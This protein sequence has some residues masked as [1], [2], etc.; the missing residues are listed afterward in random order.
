MCEYSHAMGNSN[1]SLADYWAAIEATP[2]LQGGFVWEW[3][4]HGLRQQLPDG[5]TRLAYGGQFG[6]RRHDGNFVADGLMSA[7]LEPHPA[8]TEVAWVHRPI[9]VAAGD[10]GG[11]VV[12]N[13]QSFTDASVLDA[14]WELLLD[15][16]A[17][18]GGT[19]SLPSVPP[20]ARV[21][22][23]IPC[24]VPA[25]AGEAHLALRFAHRDAT[26]FAPAGHV[27]AWDQ[28][29][30]R[31]ATS[32]RRS[33]G[34]VAAAVGVPELQLWRAPIDND[35]FKLM[36]WMA[37][38]GVGGAAMAGWQHAGLDGTPADEL[39]DHRV[40]RHADGRFEHQV[41]L[42]D[43]FPDPARVGVQFML[44]ARFTRV[45]WFG[46][47]PGENYP[48]RNAGSLVGTWESGI[49]E[50][51]Y[52]VP[53]EFGLRTDCRWFELVDPAS[54]DAVRVETVEPAL[55]HCSATHHTSADLA[56]AATIGELHRRP[57]VV[58][59]VDAAHRGLG[60]ASCGPDVLE[61]YE[62]RARS[63]RFSYRIVEA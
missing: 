40:T 19:W 38:W 58:V 27:V 18:D 32:P 9:T 54:G 52:L 13:R 61:Q 34:T 24:S 5:T 29:V 12:H 45:R 49:D 25:D 30:L 31:S 36:P 62:L 2:G 50:C 59:H 44:P 35:G 23:E 51:P 14:S 53:Q 6:E 21:H 33:A 10:D 42:P 60:T 48:D 57:E 28:L 4:D 22:V 39:V 7:D 8:M 56:A 1:G 26:W 47:G 43:G 46:R 11:L 63:Y 41:Q 20:G 15:G 37:R 16:V 55:L 17:V 3:K